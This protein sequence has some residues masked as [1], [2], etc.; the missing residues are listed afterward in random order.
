MSIDWSKLQRNMC[1]SYRYVI[2]FKCTSLTNHRCNLISAR[3]LLS[4]RIARPLSYPWW[5]WRQAILGPKKDQSTVEGNTLIEN[6]CFSFWRWKQ[7]Y[8]DKCSDTRTL[9]HW[10]NVGEA[11]F[12]LACMAIACVLLPRKFPKHLVENN[13]TWPYTD[14]FGRKWGAIQK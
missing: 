10:Q 9:S 12:M 2:I 14:L 8:G 6:S 11:F 7:G 5:W 3:N 13:C 4:S 1:Q